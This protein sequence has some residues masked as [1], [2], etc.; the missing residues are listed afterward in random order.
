LY[1]PWQEGGQPVMNM[2]LELEQQNWDSIIGKRD[3]ADIVAMPVFMNVII[4][5]ILMDVFSSP[6]NLENI[7]V[8]VLVAK[9]V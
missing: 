2:G 4:T 9:P 6:H 7:D 1:H 5:Y 3:V 8:N